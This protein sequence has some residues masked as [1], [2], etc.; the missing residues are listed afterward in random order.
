MAK[1]QAQG[2]QIALV[3]FIVLTLML[4]VATYLFYDQ[5]VKNQEAYK[6]ALAELEKSQKYAQGALDQLQ[7]LIAAAGFSEL[8]PEHFGAD[9]DAPDPHGPTILARILYDLRNEQDQSYSEALA[10]LETQTSQLQQQIQAVRKKY[11]ELKTKLAQKRAEEKSKREELKKLFGEAKQQLAQVEEET[12]RKYQAQVQEHQS[13]QEEANKAK[14]RQK[15]IELKLAAVRKK[16]SEQIAMLREQ[17]KN[18]KELEHRAASVGEPVGKVV[19]VEFPVLRGRRASKLFRI[20]IVPEAPEGFVYIDIG[21]QDFVRPQMTFSVWDPGELER[22]RKLQEERQSQEQAQETP[23]SQKQPS[24]PATKQA[25]SK[26]EAALAARLTPAPKAHIEVLEVVGPHLSKARITMNELAK[27]IRPGDLIF[28][29]IFRPGQRRHFALL[30]DFD[31]PGG[32]LHERDL[33]IYVIEKQGGVV[34]AYV[35]ENGVIH[36]D[37]PDNP[38]SPRIDWL[39]LGKLP[40]PIPKELTEKFIAPAEKLGVEIIDQDKL[41]SYLGMNQ[42]ALALARQEIAAAKR[43]A[44]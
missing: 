5:T 16:T 22:A 32:A 40:H 38:I 10:R 36:A 1:A 24:A 37:D 43:S 35:D 2:L 39:V 12:D 25:A 14:R 9:S 23:A 41:Y 20:Q 4:S 27:P 30:G 6:A 3:V 18:F 21:K 33:L 31:L 17:Q 42:R 13:M 29:P 34:D 26:E 44:D 8:G 19:R 28:S 7:M 15:E 11:D